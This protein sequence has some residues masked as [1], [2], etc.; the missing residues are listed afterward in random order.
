MDKRYYYR[1][2]GVREGASISEIRAAYGKQMNKLKQPDYAD[3]PEYVARKMDQMRHAYRVLTGAA[4]PA[5]KAQ[6][7]ARFEKWK[8]ALDGGED[9]IRDVKRAFE[10]HI[11]DCESPEEKESRFRKIGT[12]GKKKTYYSPAEQEQ[13]GNENKS[14]LAKFLVTGVALLSVFSS[15]IG[16]CANMMVSSVEELFYDISGPDYAIEEVAP[17]V[18]E[19]EEEKEALEQAL[20]RIESIAENAELYD[21]YGWLDLSGQ[22]GLQRNVIWTVDPGASA[23]IYD[24]IWGTMT[25]IAF[26]LGLY[27]NDAALWAITGDEN[28][29]WDN[30][31]YTNSLVLTGIMNP[32]AFEE[33]GG[34]INLYSG[35]V[36]LDYGA[37]L[38]F[39]RDVAADQTESIAGP[40]EW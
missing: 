34:G 5:T 16:A 6:K 30:D 37:Y 21:Y 9:A 12:A 10:K 20:V 28:F 15:L 22:E 33:I 1:L 24:E 7:E 29:Y 17:A 35:E 2:L 38:R 19:G 3:D 31:D 13:R 36:I 40:A 25:D 4:A 18:P 32:P 23:E 11:R 27:S 8:D 14:R 39:L 26:Y